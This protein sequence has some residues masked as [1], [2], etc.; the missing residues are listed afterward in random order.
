MKGKNVSSKAV[1]FGEVI[2]LPGE[3]KDI[4]VEYEKNPILEYYKRNGILKISGEATVEEKTPEQIEA[5]KLAAE[6]KEKEEAEALRQKRLAS[7]EGISVEDLAKLA[8]E[9][10]I[11]MAECKDNADILKKVK[12][13]LRK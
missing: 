13:A 4:P 6:Q 2:I 1:G 11:N 7:L 10:E 8:N 12:A 5:E 3:M 9:L